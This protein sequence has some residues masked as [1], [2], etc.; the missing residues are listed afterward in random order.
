M[1]M[2]K[3]VTY[4]GVETTCSGSSVAVSTAKA[5]ATTVLG[6]RS[7]VGG[8]TGCSA[9][10]TGS[11]RSRDRGRGGLGRSNGADGVGSWKALGVVGVADDTGVARDTSRTAGVSLTS[12]LSICRLSCLGRGAEDSN[13]EKKGVEKHDGL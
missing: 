6:E 3:S 2:Q 9:T 10:T 8:A 11:L 13:G 7:L 1:L 5:I 12:T 4:A